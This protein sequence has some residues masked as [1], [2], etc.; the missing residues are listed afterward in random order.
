MEMLTNSKCLF[1]AITRSSTCRE[2]WF[3]INIAVVKEEYDGQEISKSGHVDSDQHTPDGLTK[4]QIC[5]ALNAILNT[6]KL[7][8]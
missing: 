5:Q 6:G 2:K 4:A 8:F 3:I 1:D 7:Q